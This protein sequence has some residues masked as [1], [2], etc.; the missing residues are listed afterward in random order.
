MRK[1]HKLYEDNIPEIDF[2]KSVE[3]EISDHFVTIFHYS[4]VGNSTSSDMVMLTQEQAK[5]MVN[6]LKEEFDAVSI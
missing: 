6:L 1:S 5:L 4:K 2:Y 3:V